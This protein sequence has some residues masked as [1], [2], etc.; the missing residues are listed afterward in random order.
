VTV[1]QSRKVSEALTSI[2]S[3]ISS[4]VDM[5]HQIASA[6]EEQSA[7]ATNID[8]TVQ[9]ISDLGQETAE[10]ANETLSASKEMSGLTG[11]LQAV[12]GTFTI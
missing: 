10:N 8:T 12:V 1:D 7:V 6:A 2:A 4:I 9:L 11:S 3:S 5:S